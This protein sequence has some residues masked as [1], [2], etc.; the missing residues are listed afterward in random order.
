MKTV[1]IENVTDV[2]QTC[3]CEETG[4]QHSLFPWEVRPFP[5]PVANL[6]LDQCSGRVVKF[7]HC[8]V[9]REVGE[10]EVWVA[11]VTGNPAYP[12]VV[13]YKLY[14]STIKGYKE[15]SATNELATP[16]T[17]KFRYNPGQK[18]DT[19]N[20]KLWNQPPRTI[21]LPA[22]SRRPL[23]MSVA[24]PWLDSC[25]M[26]QSNAK[27]GLA[28]IISR[29]PT[30]WEAKESWELDDLIHYGEMLQRDFKKGLGLT[31]S[32]EHPEPVNEKERLD[33]DHAKEADRVK[34]W[35]HIYYF[36]V[37]PQVNLPSEA[38]YLKSRTHFETNR[39][40]ELKGKFG[41]SKR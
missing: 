27:D 35:Q 29:A 6:F 26:M 4:E 19:V 5:D 15:H 31:Y 3:W 22:Y 37:N 38:A 21:K 34:A 1:E 25:A 28:L 40:E 9:T 30:D 8:P 17:I 7:R 23:P 2:Q 13:T 24:R 36:L 18:M 33:T 32:W 10:E 14:D 39:N 41:K 20:K 16:M 11:N 12:A